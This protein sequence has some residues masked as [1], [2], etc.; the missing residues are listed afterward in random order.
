M[1]ANFVSV[2]NYKGV[3]DF[4]YFGDCKQVAYT[5]DNLGGNAHIYFEDKHGRHYT[6]FY[7]KYAKRWELSGNYTLKWPPEFMDVLFAAM[8]LAR[9]RHGL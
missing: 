3:L 6:F 1:I 2:E 8:D 7:S 9:E 5:M 4:E